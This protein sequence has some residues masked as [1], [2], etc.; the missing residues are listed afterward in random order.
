[1]DFRFR[2]M[3]ACDCSTFFVEADTKASTVN[4]RC[5]CCDKIVANLSFYDFK[6]GVDKV[7]EEQDITT[8]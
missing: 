6:L 2:C 5:Q 1:M 4:L 8:D 7:H 3:C